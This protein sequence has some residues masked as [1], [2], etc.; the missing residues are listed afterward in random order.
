MYQEK[1]ST[2]F[3]CLILKTINEIRLL[4]MLQLCGRGIPASANTTWPSR[5]WENHSHCQSCS[6][7]SHMATWSTSSYKI[8]FCISPESHYR[9]IIKNYFGPM[10]NFDIWT[11]IMG[12]TCKLLHIGL[13]MPLGW[14][15]QKVC[16]SYISFLFSYNALWWNNATTSPKQSV[17][18]CLRTK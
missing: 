1:L 16:Q 14:S 6:V 17:A 10:L 15:D 3:K 8:C 2:C 7:L 18:W 13:C 9:A 4:C 11:A 5:L 12:C